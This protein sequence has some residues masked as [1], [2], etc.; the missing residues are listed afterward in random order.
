M[1]PIQQDITQAFFTSSSNPAMKYT[2]MK[3]YF[4][5]ALQII[6]WSMLKLMPNQR[7]MCGSIKQSVSNPK[8]TCCFRFYMVEAPL[9]AFFK[10]RASELPPLISE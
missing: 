7:L 9:S 6:H 8:L 1:L 10:N 3:C 4:P 2:L 5:W